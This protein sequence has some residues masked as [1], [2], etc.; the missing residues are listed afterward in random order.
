MSSVQTVFAAGASAYENLATDMTAMQLTA[1]IMFALAVLHTFAV[2]QFMHF[3]KKFPEGSV[4]ENLFHFLGEVEVVFGIWAGL[5]VTFWSF[6]FG[7]A[8]SVA[9][10]DSINFTEPAFVFVIM[11][12]AATRPIMYAA[13][14]AINTFTRL[15]PLPRSMARYS[16]IMILGPLLGSLITEP[17]AMT[18]SAL[19]L[20]RYFFDTPIS[21]RFKYA[22]LGLLFVNVS[23]G[24]TLTHFAAPPV[25]MVAATWK[26]DTMFMLTHFGWKSALCVG[27]GT[28]LTTALFAKELLKLDS[29]KLP[30]ENSST[31]TPP[32]WV[33][34]LQIVFIAMTI[35]QAH[36]MSFFIPLFLFFMGWTTVS[37]EYQTPLKL[38]ESLLVGFFLGGLV[39][40]GKLQEW[41]L[42]PLIGSLDTLTLYFGATAL[43]A[44][45]DNAALTYLGTL[46]PSLSDAMKYALV[47]GAVTGG[48]LTVIA[49]APNPAGFGILQSSFGDEGISPLGLFLGAM[50]S[51]ILA[52]LAFTL[53]P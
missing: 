47:A 30:A 23:I 6:R 7:S 32:P 51:T 31:M 27:M 1:T 37:K 16:T 50:P 41:W 52:I 13:E 15:L 2:K 35:W 39:T 9:Y 25:L 44:V 49:N 22:T 36:H 4:G 5:L 46:V 21:R 10:L 19:L 33:V 43:T 48:G 12:M 38:R 11:C 53:L 3:A 20:K 42:Q 45:T 8:S 40:M 26:W 24:G 14:T 29:F 17:A 34:A 28:I 18:V